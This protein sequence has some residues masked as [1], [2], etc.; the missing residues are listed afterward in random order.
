MEPCTSVDSCKI[1]SNRTVG[2]FNSGYRQ[3]VISNHRFSKVNLATL[4]KAPFSITTKP[5]C[6]GGRY[7]IPWIASAC[8]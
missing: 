5:K 6:R 8:P 1:F 7:S 4:V 2:I 3:N